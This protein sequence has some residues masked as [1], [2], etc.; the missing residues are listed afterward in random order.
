MEVDDGDLGIQLLLACE[1]SQH[2]QVTGLLFS[3]ADVHVS[4]A[5]GRTP[6]LLACSA[7]D[8][9]IVEKIL[10]AGAYIQDVDNNGYGATLLAAESGSLNLVQW[11]ASTGQAMF[12][13]RSDDGTTVLLSASA[14][15][16]V[17]LVKW[18]L[19][20]SGASFSLEDRDE[21]G[22]DCVLAAAEA[23]SPSLVKELLRRG[24][25]AKTVDSHGCGI[26]HYAAAGGNPIMVEFCVKQL[27]IS[28]SVQ[29]ADGDT[30]LLIAA[31]EGH[32]STVES[33]LK[34]KSNPAERNHA[35]MS[36]L[37]TAAVG[38]ESGDSG[39]M[40]FLM[41]KFGEN[42]WAGEIEQNPELVLSYLENADGGSSAV[43]ADVEM[44]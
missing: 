7:G 23:G 6:I 33:M 35:G 16:S 4:D 30:P 14:S 22:A 37:F 18:L 26:M 17:E 31:H 32:V 20:E 40:D 12:E 42:A 28:C 34:L 43:C 9:S 27:K 24:M 11:L 19:D 36:V 13:E 41:Q 39:M 15:G 29:D 3:G 5:D 2:E 21:R 44:S 10:E 8:L 1:L 25:C 38:A